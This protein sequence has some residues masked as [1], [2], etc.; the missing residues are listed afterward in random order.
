MHMG[1]PHLGS[2]LDEQRSLGAK[3]F[4]GGF[5]HHD[6]PL[7]QCRSVAELDAPDELRVQFS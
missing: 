5:V 1:L 7:H 4:L 6:L 3:I 2:R